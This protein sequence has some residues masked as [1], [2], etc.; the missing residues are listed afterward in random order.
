RVARAAGLVPEL[1]ATERGHVERSLHLAAGECVA[2][3]AATSGSDAV[4]DASLLLGGIGPHE[5]GYGEHVVHPATCAARNGDAIARVAVEGYDDG[6]S[7]PPNEVTLTLAR[8]HVADVYA[9][10]RLVLT[11]DA[12]RLLGGRAVR[13][14]AARVVTNGT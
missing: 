11:A 9:Y 2:L 5:R 13:A 10:P 1:E 8:G 14:R 3:L 12:A 7:G 6:W 4:V